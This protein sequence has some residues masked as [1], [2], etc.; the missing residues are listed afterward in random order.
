MSLVAE[1]KK[2]N[3]QLSL[4]NAAFQQH[5]GAMVNS[6]QF[7][8]FLLTFVIAPF[9]VGVVAKRVLGARSAVAAQVFRSA[10]LGW[11]L[12]SRL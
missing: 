6:P 5:V 12:R 3:D 7:N 8:S 9:I 11:R 1:I 2:K 10:L 4:Q